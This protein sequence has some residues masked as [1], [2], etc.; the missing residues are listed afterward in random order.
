MLVA[1]TTV[2]GDVFHTE[3]NVITHCKAGTFFNIW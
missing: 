1:K 3:Q 2:S